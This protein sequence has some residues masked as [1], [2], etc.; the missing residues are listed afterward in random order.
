[1][2]QLIKNLWTRLAKVQGA[3]RVGFQQGEAGAVPKS[4]ADVGGRLVARDD[5]ATA[6]DFAAAAATKP[7]VDAD[8]V[9]DAVV[10]KVGTR[11]TKLSEAIGAALEASNAQGAELCFIEQFFTGFY[12]RGM[13][14]A[15]AYN[16]ATEEVIPS[17]RAAGSTTLLVT[18]PGAFIDGSCVT[19]KH[20]NGKYWTYLVLSRVGA[21]LDITPS[22]RWTCTAG[23]ARIERA[24]YNRAHAGKFYM[25]QLAQRL[26][27]ATNFETAIDTGRAVINTTFS[28]GETANLTAIGG[29][30]IYYYNATALGSDGTVNKPVRFSMRRTAYIEISAGGDG[31]KTDAFELTSAAPHVARF[32]FSV[33]ALDEATIR[34]VGATTGTVIG[35]KT[36][37]ASDCRALSVHTIRVNPAAVEPVYAQIT[38]S[39]NGV[40]QWAAVSVHEAPPV[41]G[42]LISGAGPKI[43]V[44]GDSWVQGD[45]GNTV[46]R[47]PITTQLQ[48]ELP[49]ST[50]VNSGI[51]GQKIWDMLARFDADVAAHAPSHVVI[52]TGTNECYS[53]ASATFDPT[54]ID[55][56]FLHIQKMIARVREIGAKPILVGNAAMP[57]TDED[58]AGLAEWTLHTRSTLYA[59]GYATKLGGIPAPV[60]VQSGA[61][62]ERVDLTLTAGTTPSVAGARRVNLA[63]GAAT[64]ITQFAGG[65]KGQILELYAENGNVTLQHGLLLLTGSANVTLTANSV[66]TLVRLDPASSDGWVE[67]SRSIK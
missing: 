43:V 23:T 10:R 54:G 48:L 57:Q 37:A 41:A 25:R 12:G 44:I 17:T 61:M 2:S 56:F 18:T 36:V 50:I 22:L 42:S 19:V 29:A 63:Y 46:Q 65:K 30:A 5:F 59:D 67:K 21:Q 3:E 60:G 7:S 32:V 40:I 9:F 33:A 66:I 11:K 15:E 4:L 26:A 20:D 51:G 38:G 31:V 55:D 1:M 45:M 52:V 13:L 24:W 28:G 39:D 49:S 58:A 6:E 47:E 27:D 34:I 16:T 35:E 14:T 8:N 53:P 62:Y 64:T